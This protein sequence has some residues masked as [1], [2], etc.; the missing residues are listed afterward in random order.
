[1]L[2]I[3]LFSRARKNAEVY[4]CARTDSPNPA[5]APHRPNLQYA[6]PATTPTAAASSIGPSISKVLRIENRNASHRRP[7]LATSTSTKIPVVVGC[8]SIARNRSNASAER[9]PHEVRAGARNGSAVAS[10]NRHVTSSRY[11]RYGVVR[12]RPTPASIVIR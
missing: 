7:V 11:P 2:W 4:G 9:A 3:Q 8:V 1:M 6:A 5:F 10:R 12:N